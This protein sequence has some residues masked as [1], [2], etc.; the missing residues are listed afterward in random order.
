MGRTYR[1]GRLGRCGDGMTSDE[2]RAYLALQRRV[3]AEVWPGYRA[4]MARAT[5]TAAVEA[6]D[7]HAWAEVASVL[8]VEPSMPPRPFV[9]YQ[10]AG[11]LAYFGHRCAYCDR[12]LPGRPWKHGADPKQA[13]WTLDMHLDHVTPKVVCG[14]NNYTNYVPA[15]SACNMSKHARGLDEWRRGK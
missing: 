6:F 8:E 11:M 7:T 9:E 14:A 5:S 3:L 1:V 10:H 15:C 12:V 13:P 2:I 4:D